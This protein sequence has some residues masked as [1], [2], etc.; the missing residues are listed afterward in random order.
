MRCQ[1]MIVLSGRGL[2]AVVCAGLVLSHESAMAVVG[3]QDSPDTPLANATVSVNGA[4]GTLVSNNIV[5]TNGHVT[6]VVPPPMSPPFSRTNAH[7]PGQWHPLRTGQVNVFLGAPNLRMTTTRRDA[8]TSPRTRL[9]LDDRNRGDFVSGD[10]I[11]LTV[12]GGHYLFVD[13]G[14]FGGD[15]RVDPQFNRYAAWQALRVTKVSGSA[16]PV[17]RGG[18]KVT[19]ATTD[20]SMLSR[21]NGDG[22]VTANNFTAGADA[23]WTVVSFGPGGPISTEPIRHGAQFGLASSVPDLGYLQAPVKMEATSIATPGFDDIAMVRLAQPVPPALA[24]PVPMKLRLGAGDGGSLE[25]FYRSANLRVAGY[26]LVAGRAGARIRQ[27][28]VVGNAVREQDHPITRYTARGA[29]RAIT[30]SGDS[31]GSFFVETPA[32][33]RLVGI[34]QQ[35][36]N[37]FISPLLRGG[38]DLENNSKPDLHAWFSQFLADDD[39]VETA[40]ESGIVKERGQAIQSARVCRFG[41]DG[42]PYAVAYVNAA[43]ALPNEDCIGFTASNL[44]LRRP[45]SPEGTGSNAWVV[46]SGNVALLAVEGSWQQSYT[47]GSYLIDFLRRGA[48]SKMCFT[49][50]PNPRLVY[51]RR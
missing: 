45:S 18:D 26:G 50:R 40:S 3:G 8:L 35:E 39:C 23:E 33:R 46:M 11:G 5:V 19:I 42:K 12:A 27:E 17:I 44:T 13:G 32:G 10:T 41:G 47:R 1:D 49:N 9:T 22:F 51:F 16:G 6:N 30:Q 38:F 34:T 2:S 14:V 7:D 4:S 48:M 37:N 24:V 43:R 15:L 29:G 25:A 21:N 36:N 28:A 31:G 20:G